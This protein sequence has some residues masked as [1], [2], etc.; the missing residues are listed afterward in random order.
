AS[1]LENRPRRGVVGVQRLQTLA[2]ALRLGGPPLLFELIGAL[3]RL[4][5]RRPALRPGALA[6]AG[7]R[8]QF[9][10]G[11]GNPRPLRGDVAEGL[12][13]PLPHLVRL[14]EP[15]LLTQPHP[16]LV[17]P[18]RLAHRPGQP[19]AGRLPAP[20]ARLLRLADEPL[21]L[22]LAEVRVPFAQ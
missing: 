22:L 7:G 16:L 11:A 5:D 14:V 8:R 18:V 2:D 12:D 17:E 13:Q 1:L 10:A 9:R 4:A 19:G 6:L 21:D 15:A 20:V 3:Q